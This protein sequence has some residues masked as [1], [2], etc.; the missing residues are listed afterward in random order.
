[1]PCRNRGLIRAPERGRRFPAWATC[2]VLFAAGV[3]GAYYGCTTGPLESADESRLLVLAGITLLVGAGVAGSVLPHRL[4]T[5][6]LFV[7][8]AGLLSGWVC[9]A[10]LF[11]RLQMQYF[12]VSTANIARF[13]AVVTEDSRI[14][15]R[16]RTQ[17]VAHVFRVYPGGGGWAS[18]CAEVMIDA[19]SGLRLNRGERLRVDSRIRR[20]VPDG[21][22]STP[23][24]L[25][26]VPCRSTVIAAD[27]SRLGWA[28]AEAALRASLL[29]ALLRTAERAGGQNS[30]L[31]QA[32]LTGN[33]DNLAAG[34]AR[35]FRR[36]GCAHILALSGMHLGVLTAAIS[37]LFARLFSRR[38]AYVVG[39]LFVAGYVWLA[40]PKPSL[41]R[42]ALMFGVAGFAVFRGRRLS[43]YHALALCFALQ[44]LLQPAAGH[45]VSFGL[46]YLAIAG[47]IV[48]SSVVVR[49]AGA[50]LTPP[51]AALVG[52]GVGA[53]ISV[54]PLSVAVFGEVFPFG[55]A[56]AVVLGPLVTLYIWTGL[57]SMSVAVLAP[58]VSD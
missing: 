42:A 17:A 6:S 58:L 52:A 39:L 12:G 21:G 15:A 14:V 54:L 1:M 5:F 49:G 13:D 4:A 36:A 22:R 53:Q 7:L 25:T 46:S 10:A 47:V 45:A 24:V 20:A 8:A 19:P 38:A 33:Q 34:V 51:G 32:L 28:S 55:I 56:A 40:G 3:A 11:S 30:P 48:G 37:L 27:I 26:A 31:L 44:L 2:P 41:V 50:L 57:V 29:T 43:P 35:Q 9:A 23:E 16:G 18:S